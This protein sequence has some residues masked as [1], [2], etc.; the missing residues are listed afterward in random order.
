MTEPS[1][2]RDVT[3]SLPCGRCGYRTNVT[4]RIDWGGAILSGDS[5]TYEFRCKNCFHT[6]SVPKETLTQYTNQFV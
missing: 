4:V 1:E 2:G 6:F 5:S 3:F